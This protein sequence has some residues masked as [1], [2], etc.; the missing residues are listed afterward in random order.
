LHLITHQPADRL[1]SQLDPAQLSRG[2]KIKD[3][4]VI[5]LN[6]DD[7]TRRGISNHDVVRVFNARGACLAAAVL[8]PGVMPRVAV[9]ATGAWFDPQASADAPERH[10]NPNVLT[11][12]IGTSRLTQGPS[13]LSALVDVERWDAELPPTSVFT[14]PIMIRAGAAPA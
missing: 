7:A 6:P 13:A 4:E 2:N 10:G 3:R 11:H 8:D 1:H 12:D 9:M 14:P 5:R